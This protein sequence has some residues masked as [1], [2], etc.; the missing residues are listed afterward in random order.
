MSQ[1]N[2]SERSHALSPVSLEFSFRIDGTSDPD[3][4]RCGGV[5]FVADDGVTRESAGLFTVQFADDDVCT[6]PTQLTS[7]SVEVHLPTAVA[8]AEKAITG[9]VVGL[10][11]DTTLRTI[12]VLTVTANAAGP[13]TNPAAADPEDNAWVTVRIKGPMISDFADA[14]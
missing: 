11:I 14:A 3:A 2:R 7:A 4:T 1:M 9:S 8:T 5:K 12:S 13:A 10:A 6:L